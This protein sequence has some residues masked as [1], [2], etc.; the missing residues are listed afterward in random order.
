MNEDFSEVLDS[1]PE[2]IAVQDIQD[3]AHK[4][5][6]VILD[7]ALNRRI[8]PIRMKNRNLTPMELG[9]AVAQM[10]EKLLNA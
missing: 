2:G 4:F 8:C 6:M 5:T 1:I 10:I 3:L 9:N 7:E